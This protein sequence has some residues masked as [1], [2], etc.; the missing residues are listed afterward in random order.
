MQKNISNAEFLPWSIDNDIN[1]GHHYFVSGCSNL[2]SNLG[3]WKFGFESFLDSRTSLVFIDVSPLNRFWLT[4]TE[5]LVRYKVFCSASLFVV[6]CHL[7]GY[8][9][10]KY[11]WTKLN[12]NETRRPH[13]R[14][15]LKA[16]TFFHRRTLPSEKSPP[17]SLCTHYFFWTLIVLYKGL[18]AESHLTGWA[19]PRF[20]EGRRTQT[21]TRTLAHEVTQPLN[22]SAAQLPWHTAYGAQSGLVKEVESVCM[23]DGSETPQSHWCIV[24]KSSGAHKNTICKVIFVRTFRWL[25]TSNPFFWTVYYPQTRSLC[26]KVP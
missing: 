11:D 6:V 17:V 18:H 2:M 13:V 25:P 19:Q 1:F 20:V 14:A 5:W 24:L 8:V 3:D 10:Q 4:W 12:L 16:M 15:T 22:S 23:S 9:F 7:R 26:L 21:R